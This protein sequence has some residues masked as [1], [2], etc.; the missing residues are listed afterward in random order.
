M[1]PLELEAPT[2]SQ[3]QQASPVALD[4]ERQEEEK[5]GEYTSYFVSIHVLDLCYCLFSD[6]L[7]THSKLIK[8]V[9]VAGYS[10]REA[11][12]CNMA[13]DRYFLSSIKR[14]Q[15]FITLNLPNASTVIRRHGV[16][17]L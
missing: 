15:D 13:F 12:Y 7:Y 1:A 9:L 3:F 6:F 5:L 14:I 8:L 4:L 16:Y 2:S 11:D 17:V 10:P